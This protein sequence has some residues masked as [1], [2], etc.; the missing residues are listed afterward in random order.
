MNVRHRQMKTSTI[1]LDLNKL[2][3]VCSNYRLLCDAPLA[4]LLA[5]SVIF[6]NT[7]EVMCLFDHT[8]EC[9][10]YRIIRLRGL[11]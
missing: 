11:T 9:H 10:V 7:D 5:R 3:R 2:L 6:C 1:D 4:L 8:C